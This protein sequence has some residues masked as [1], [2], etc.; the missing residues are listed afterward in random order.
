MAQILVIDDRTKRLDWFQD[1][2]EGLGHA[3][4]LAPNGEIAFDQLH[5][6][7]FDLAFFDHDLGEEPNGSQIATR[8]LHSAKYHVPKAIW[9][10]TSNTPG[11]DNIA[12]KFYSAGIHVYIES[13]EELSKHPDTFKAV[14][15]AM[16]TG[17]TT[18]PG[19]GRL[20]LPRLQP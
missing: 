9:V 3:V 18:V 1:I 7:A 10:H 11:A 20:I 19:P 5:E 16:L 13:F 4:R 15:A 8:I 12:S 17:A 2:L 14:L 6:T